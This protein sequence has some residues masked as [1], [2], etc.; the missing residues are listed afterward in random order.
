MDLT[1]LAKYSGNVPLNSGLWSCRAWL[2]NCTEAAPKLHRKKVFREEPV[3]IRKNR[4]HGS[5]VDSYP[6]NPDSDKLHR[7]FQNHRHILPDPFLQLMCF[8]VQDF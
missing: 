6:E 3:L 2:K 4:F 7:F 1:R 5:G 8:S